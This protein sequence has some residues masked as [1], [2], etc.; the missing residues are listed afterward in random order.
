LNARVASRASRGLLG[1][2]GR[3]EILAEAARASPSARSAA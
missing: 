2:G 1:S 3:A